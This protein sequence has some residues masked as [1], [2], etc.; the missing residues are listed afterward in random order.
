MAG[1]ITKSKF[2]NLPDGSTVE[3]FT[4]SNSAGLSCK[5]IN[6]GGIITELH[7]PDKNG[8][9]GDVV[10]GFDN[11]QQ[12]LGGHPYFGAITGRYAN[13][14]A[15]G[16][17]TLDGKTYSLAVNNGPN[18]LHGGLKG[19][20][21]VM[22]K[23][24]PMESKD[25][26]ALK[27]TYTSLDGQ[28]NYP[29]TLNI[30]VTYTLTDKN[31]VRI[32]YEADTNKATPINLTN[33]SY[34]NLAGAGSGDVFGHELTLNAKNFTPT[35]DTLIPT[36]EIKPVKGTPFDFTEPKAIAKDIGQLLDQP[37][38]GYDH[39]FV[40]DNGGKLSLAARV[41]EPKSGRV[42]ETLTDQPGVQLYTA[43]FLADT[44][45]KGGSVYGKNG[46]FCLET[47]HFPDSPNHPN[48]PSTILRPGE[49]YR[50]TTIYRFAVE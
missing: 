48:F 8:K 45:G 27:L 35:D 12:Y 46:G 17:F 33:H 38:R 29:G 37:H 34:F 49:K 2:G 22:W 24:T 20:D 6:Y 47:Q 13:R 30:T 31:E 42:M 43:N 28:E 16:K 15:K 41:F 18:H 7:A 25:G 4:L 36:G 44:R 10:L 50:T 1:K 5:I 40:L 14:I 11:F 21:K 26:P 3:Q 32:D 23:A 39:N 19:F 9:L